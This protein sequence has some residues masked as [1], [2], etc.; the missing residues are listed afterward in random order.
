MEPGEYV[1]VPFNSQGG[2][3]AR[4]DVTATSASI[5]V[6]TPGGDTQSAVLVCITNYGVNPAFVA[7]G[8]S[9]QTATT[10][11][12]CVLPGTQTVWG[13]PYVME[14]PLYMAAICESG[15][16]T[17]LQITRGYGN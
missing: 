17:K 9:P 3:G 14:A 15:Q 10:N 11:H 4:L 12:Q 16:T 7:L 13:I 5:A 1:V 2:V 8:K 6:P